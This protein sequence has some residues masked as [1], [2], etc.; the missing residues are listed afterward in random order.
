VRYS[1]RPGLMPRAGHGGRVIAVAA[2]AL[3][4]GGCSAAGSAP[5]APAS[6]DPAAR[7]STPPAGRSSPPHHR[8]HGFT[9]SGSFPVTPNSSQDTH[10][11]AA[12]APCRRSEFRHARSLGMTTAAGFT[13][14][15]APVAGDLLGHFLD[16]KGTAVR[17]G[18]RSPIAR[19]AR[20][21]TAFRE[22]NRRVQAAVLSQLA[23]GARHVRLPGSDLTPV[24]F[25]LAGSAHDLYLGFRGTQGLTV[26]GAGTKQGGRYT[27]RLTYVIRD[28]YG[29]PPQ[30]QLLGI[31]TQMRYLQVNCGS[32]D[33]RGGARWFPDSITV[34]VPFRHAAG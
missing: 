3:V 23:A 22:L 29:F 13:I 18:P 30:D 24:Y 26:R 16:G 1:T 19:E 34:S 14:T 11:Q 4:A 9:V 31:G 17:Y 15:N 8:R 21:S 25:D 12:G 20:A 7:S 27:G 10:A 28:S 33:F 5:S 6:S 2:A 32:P